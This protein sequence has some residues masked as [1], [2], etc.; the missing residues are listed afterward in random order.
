[1]EKQ[2]NNRLKLIH[3]MKTIPLL[4]SALALTVNGGAQNIVETSTYSWRGDTIFQGEFRAWA[5]SDDCILST[6]SAQPGY[7]MPV[8]KE[9]KVK[10]DLSP[11][12]RL[13]S[14][15]RLH[16]AI[17]NMGLDEMINNVEPDS[18]LRTGKEWSGVWTRDV[19]YSIILSMGY[20][21]PLASKVSLMKKVNANGRIIQ[22]TGSGGA[23]PVSSDR[24]IWAVAAYE[25]YK[26]TGDRDWLE[27]IYPVISNSMEDDLQ[28]L[29][30]TSGLVRGET[31]F[32]DWREQSYPKW[33]QTV[34]IYQSESL[35]T[36][37]V[38]Y[39]AL[40]VL[41]DIAQELGKKQE[42]A[43]YAGLADKLKEVI[44]RELWLDDKG[45]YAMYRYGRNHLILNPRV[46][47]LGE[48]L[49]ILFGVAPQDRAERIT[50]NNPNTPYGV[51]IFYPQIKDMPS[52][53]NN[54][55]WP[56]VA[57]YWAL[58]NA[59]VKNEVGAL[60]AI[61]SV[62]RPAALFATNKENFNLDNGDIATELNSSN[63]LWSLAGNLALTYRMLFGIHFETDGLRF[64]PFV[65]KAL[66][67]TRTLTNFRY[68]NAVLDITVEG[69]GDRIQS[70]T[71]NG[72]ASE[73][74][75]GAKAKGKLDIR[76]VMANQDI[77]PM[78]VTY[79]PNRKAPLTP[80]SRLVEMNGESYL[81]W[82]PIEYIAGY[83]VIRNGEVIATT[84]NTSYRLETPGEYQVLGFDENGIESFASEPVQYHSIL[85]QS[86]GGKAT[87]LGS[88]QVSY[89]PTEPVSGFWGEGFVELDRQ[90]G[91]VSIPLEL[92][93]DGTYYLALHYAN[94]NGPVNTENKAAIR[95]LLVDGQKVGTVVMP[96]RGQG[97]WYD[98]GLSNSI[99]VTLT[100]GNYTLTIE[101]RPENEN[102]NLN[103]NHALVDAVRI[104]CP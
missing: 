25:L 85:I 32:I 101:F 19:S 40:R 26:V 44:N 48:S 54:A 67:D 94:G 104:V 78:K 66:S 61:G 35:S 84:R 18:T 76:I 47:T 60:Q 59:Q 41:A 27:Y 39:Q 70:F 50:Q 103:T 36:S 6:Y 22:D 69:Y 89:Q 14:S 62:F 31:S 11:Y 95:T 64:E 73:P 63:M 43:K 30:G 87:Q 68:R 79:A 13:S 34:D 91:P 16:N 46:E 74:F 24:M 28:T 23:W 4:L 12:P 52:Y 8:D 17:Y 56:F 21:Q 7:F 82:N 5:P 49:S 38:H 81:A 100:K 1:M 96:H 58:A 86:L 72:K 9:W 83:K 55:L 90:T 15:N 75:I 45:F 53:H 37:V 93:A 65:P 20:L 77:A 97:N 102:M 57:S 42:A 10:N 3:K 71:V 29:Y 99:P 33:M 98:W 2:M 92:P 51:A 88:A 80:I